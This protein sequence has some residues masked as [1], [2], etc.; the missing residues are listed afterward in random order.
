MTFKELVRA[1]QRERSLAPVVQQH[2]AP[3]PRYEDVKKRIELELTAHAVRPG[4]W[5]NFACGSVQGELKR[6]TW[7][8]DRYGAVVRFG[9]PGH[10]HY[11]GF[12]VIVD[13][14]VVHLGEAPP[15]PR[16][17][18]EQVAVTQTVTRT[19]RATQTYRR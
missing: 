12:F 4:Y 13:G 8:Q 16:P 6:F 2:L 9:L 14:I 18:R 10:Q 7:H 3:Q 17:P 15:P 5:L 11:H 1:I 19:V